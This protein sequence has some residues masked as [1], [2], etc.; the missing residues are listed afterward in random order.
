MTGPFLIV[1]AQF[2]TSI[3]TKYYQ[4]LLAQGVCAGVGMGSIVLPATAVSNENNAIL[5]KIGV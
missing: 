2:M 4:I 3:S 5:F 1:F